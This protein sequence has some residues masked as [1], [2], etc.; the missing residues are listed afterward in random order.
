MFL[1]GVTKITTR[2]NGL[3]KDDYHKALHVVRRGDVILV[4]SLR[5]V[6]KFFIRGPV[7]HAALY[8]GKGKVIHA[9]SDGVQKD[10]FREFFS[11]YDTL[12]IMRAN[13]EADK[14][15]IIKKSI[16]Y[17]KKQIGKPFNFFLTPS[18]QEL[19][20]SQLINNAF[21]HANFNTGITNYSEAKD[22]IRKE[23]AA[24]RALHPKNFVYANFSLI[25]ASSSLKKYIDEKII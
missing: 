7:T 19:F 25:F 21:H 14:K 10:I 20:C 9:I 24:T 8:I 18:Q 22:I 4:G 15:Q 12:A 23:I 1:V 6:S 5:R 2:P 17:A 16:S 13:I 3:T 11:E